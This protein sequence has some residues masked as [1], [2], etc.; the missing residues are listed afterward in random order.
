[1]IGPGSDKKGQDKYYVV[2]WSSWP[3]VLSPGD[4]TR[5]RAL[6]RKCT[7][8][9]QIAQCHLFIGIYEYV[10]WVSVK[11]NVDFFDIKIENQIESA[12][13]FA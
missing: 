2:S 6:H 7:I 11:S 3:K 1:M 5:S 9:T 13:H 12:K 4:T 10:Y 8:Q